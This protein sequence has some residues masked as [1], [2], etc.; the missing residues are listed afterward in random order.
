MIRPL[1]R[2][3]AIAAAAACASCAPVAEEPVA[4]AG[5]STDR[6]CLFASRINGYSEAPDGPRGERLYVHTGPRDRW[7]FE[8]FGSCPELDWAHRIA[9]D[10]RPVSNLCTG[11]T[12]NL[13]V[14]RGLGGT[15]DR[16]TVR[17]L[18][19]MQDPR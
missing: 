17:M 5:L 4:S 2:L 3:A 19:K 1:P 12:A 10:T 14:P 8:T 7:L 11:D 6:Q 13:I 16:C 15:P 18:G 9:I